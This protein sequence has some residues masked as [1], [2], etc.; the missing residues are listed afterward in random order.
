MVVYFLYFLLLVDRYIQLKLNF[1]LVV[2][3][4]MASA[5][6]GSEEHDTLSQFDRARRQIRD[7]FSRTHYLLQERE[8][9]LLAEVQELEDTFRGHGIADE[10]KQLSLSKEQLENTLK[11]NKSR[12]ILQQ[13][14]ALIDEKIAELTISLEKAQ[15]MKRIDLDWNDDFEN[16]LSTLGTIQVN[17]E[18]KSSKLEPD[19]KKKGIPLEVFGQHIIDGSTAPG[20]FAYPQTIIIDIKT[21]HFYVCDSGNDRVQVFTKSFQFL[22]MFSEKMNGPNGICTFQDKMYVTQNKGNNLNIYSRECKLLSSVGQKGSGELELNGPIGVAVSSEWSKIYICEY[23]N[24]RVQCLNLD[25]TFNCFI[26]DILGANDVKVTAEEIVVLCEGN[27]C[28][29]IY[30]ASHQLSR[31]MISK[32]KEDFNQVKHPYCFFLDSNLNILITD[33]KRHCVS[34]FSSSGELIH[35]FGKEG[36]EKGEFVQP[37]GITIDSKGR[38]VVISSNPN[39][40]IQL[41]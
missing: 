21:D 5:E 22:S 18:K 28:I 8:V 10:M 6:S 2:Q 25:L 1:Y 31:Q 37:T 29:K 15:E 32:G 27:P 3:I 33:C 14:I 39:H 9:A 35:E 13:G 23:V 7:K 19:Y 30:N 34:I 38:I 40:C 4:V 17:A 26:P 20:V 16:E 11:G 41:F 36:E 12:E 24:H